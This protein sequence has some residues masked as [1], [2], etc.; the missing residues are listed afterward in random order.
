MLVP[1]IY[2]KVSGWWESVPLALARVPARIRR[3]VTKRP[4]V[5]EAA[6]AVDLAEGEAR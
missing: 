6:G 2:V 3:I 1:V 5:P 4:A